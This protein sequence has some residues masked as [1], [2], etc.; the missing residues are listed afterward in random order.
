MGFELTKVRLAI[1]VL[2]RT[3]RGWERSNKPPVRKR[4]FAKSFTILV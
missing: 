2:L 3:G 4:V 1:N